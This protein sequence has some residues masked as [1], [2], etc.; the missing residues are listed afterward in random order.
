MVSP[1]T[2]SEKDESADIDNPWRED[3]EGRDGEEHGES[4]DIDEL[5]SS[6]EPPEELEV[7][8]EGAEIAT[9]DVHSQSATVDSDGVTDINTSGA[10]SDL[11]DAEID[12]GE[13]EGGSDEENGV[14]VETAEVEKEDVKSDSGKF[15][16]DETED[17]DGTED[18]GES[19]GEEDEEGGSDRPLGSLEDLDEGGQIAADINAGVASLGVIGIEDEDVQEEL[20]EDF[21]KTA[22][23]FRLGYY[24]EQC[25]EEYILSDNDDDISP[26]WGLVV[27]AAICG[28]IFILRR[29]DTEE[30]QQKARNQFQ[31]I[32]SG[33]ED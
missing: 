33:G 17:A 3:G 19:E 25:A 23:D 8:D 13:D 26:V 24:G 14:D 11:S 7:G 12:D 6:D 31:K 4:E 22:R 20:R 15:G 2:T 21:F 10:S 18:A 5:S 30:I 32:G 1:K 27:A 29:P 16:F 9:A 28:T